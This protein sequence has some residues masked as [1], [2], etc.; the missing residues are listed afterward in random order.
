MKLIFLYALAMAFLLMPVQTNHNTRDEVEKTAELNVLSDVRTSD[1][2]RDS[3]ERRSNNNLI[4]KQIREL[5]LARG[6]LRTP[7]G[8]YFF[9]GYGT[10]IY[11]IELFFDVLI[12]INFDNTSLA[13]STFKLY[14][15]AQRNAD[16]FIPRRVITHPS[17]AEGLFYFFE[18]AEHCQPVLFQSALLIS[19]KKGNTTWMTEQMYNA[20]K[21]Y[22]SHWELY[23]DRD[24]NGLCEWASAPHG[25]SDT[26]IERAGVWQ[27]YFCEGVDLNCQRYLEY[28]AAE[29]IARAL[30]FLED[31]T[32]FMSKAEALSELI[33]TILWNKE[34]G[35]F[36]DRDIRT[37]KHIKLKHAHCFHP[38]E[39]GIATPEQAKTIVEKHLLNPKEFWS[40]YPL[41]S[42]A[43]NEAAYTQ[44]Y[45][46]PKDSNLLYYL[47]EGHCNWCGG[48]WPHTA[49]ST[50]HGL[51]RYGYKKEAQF[52][53]G[54]LTELVDKYPYLYEWYN[55]E[56]G[57]GKGS[58][59]FY[60]GAEAL[61]AFAEAELKVGFN[62]YW[63]DDVNKPLPSV[64]QVLDIEPIDDNIIQ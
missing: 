29:K 61:M 34:E 1:D 11:S 41:P 51:E 20:M 35:F 13:E 8:H 57:E 26:A 43:M 50:I 22:L 7:A 53:A 9:T 31:A 56:T 27:S 52:L 45:K 21:A 54:K 5:M 18:Q 10:S 32:L 2:G 64:R 3:E 12:L 6:I 39:C 42:Y 38:L 28:L 37:G 60:A 63:I 30:G 14:L 33:K 25:C 4:I 46:P 17:E 47:P 58:S 59:P 24:G 16:G 49:Y 23:W 15:Q 19:R 40:A 48:M 36:Y 44:H 55:A 62:P